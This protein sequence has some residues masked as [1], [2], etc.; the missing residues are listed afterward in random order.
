MEV[1]L[2]DSFQQCIYDTYQEASQDRHQ[3]RKTEHCDAL[4]PIIE[5]QLQVEGASC[6]NST[7]AELAS[8]QHLC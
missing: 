4:A 8:S 5:I 2:R 6:G 1:V 3:S 7:H